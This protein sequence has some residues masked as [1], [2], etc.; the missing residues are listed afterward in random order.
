[1]AATLR[2]LISRWRS[3]S[4][5]EFVEFA[6]AFPLLMF[7]VMGIIDFGIMFQQYEVITNAAR[8]GARIAV[9][10]GTGTYSN[11]DAVNRSQD[12]ID[13][14]IM[15]SGAINRSAYVPVVGSPVAQT[16]SG[17]GCMT[18]VTVSTAYPH[19]Y[20]F[21]SGIGTYFGASFGTKIL[22]GSAT[23]RTEAVGAACP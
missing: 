8:E 20:L 15:S 18:T 7:V 6:L 2:T 17:G 23:M 12:Y 13:T 14:A 19:R 16:L 11:T 1:M 4:G 22:S 3:A 10:V 9:L 21:I 5:A